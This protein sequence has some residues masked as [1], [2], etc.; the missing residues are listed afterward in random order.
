MN[1]ADERPSYVHK[2]ILKI[3]LEHFKSRNFNILKKK[4][5]LI[6]KVGLFHSISSF[7]VQVWHIFLLKFLA[8]VVQST[9]LY[10]GL[11]SDLMEIK[12]SMHQYTQFY[13]TKFF[14]NTIYGLDLCLCF[15]KCMLTDLL[16]LMANHI[17]KNQIQTLTFEGSFSPSEFIL[18]STILSIILDHNF[19]RISMTNI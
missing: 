10:C 5:E 3:C 6:I 17:F 19:K 1:L 18:Q 7:K 14:G 13:K 15:K 2:Y 9:L 4:I 16:L 12:Y 8:L 11:I